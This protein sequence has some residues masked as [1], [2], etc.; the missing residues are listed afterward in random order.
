MDFT[1]ER[2][3]MVAHQLKDRGITDSLLL[4]AFLKIPRHLFVESAL[5]RRA[6][7]DNP[8]PIGLGQTISQPYIVAIMIQALELTGSENV[9]EIGTGSGYMTALLSRLSRKVFSVERLKELSVKA[10]KT[11]DE[12]NIYNVRLLIGDGSCGH[13]ESGPYE[14]IVV[15]AG[16]PEIPMPL[17]NQLTP[18]GKMIIP[19]GDVEQQTLKLVKKEGEKWEVSDLDLCRFVKLVGAHG[20]AK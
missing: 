7:D 17:L 18:R 14:A 6:Y 4:A 1:H 8:L 12:L 16:S 9:L 5:F 19:I 10:Q 13:E 3:L 15:S 2:K 20:F 11:L